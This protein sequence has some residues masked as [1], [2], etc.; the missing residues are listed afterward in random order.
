MESKSYAV[1]CLTSLLASSPVS[2]SIITGNVT[3]GEALNRG[4][5]FKILVAP[6]IDSAPDSTVGN[7]NLQEA[8]LYGLDE[9][10][11]VTLTNALNVNILADGLGGGGGSGTIAQGSIVSSQYIFFDPFTTYDQQGTVS[12]NSNILGIITSRNLLNNSDFLQADGVTY[13]EPSLRG[14]EAGDSVTITNLQT[15]SVDW[16]AGSPGDY[17]R[18]VTA[19]TAVPI[20]SAIWL[21]GSGLLGLFTHLKIRRSA[22]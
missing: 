17:I 19:A 14:L 11:N 8:N 15:I 2:A 1:L 9:D 5:I 22:N 10:Q 18:V 20:P 12:F 4:G 21:F 3:G 16:S 7:N 6:F 13:L